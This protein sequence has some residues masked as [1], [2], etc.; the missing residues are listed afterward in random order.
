MNKSRK[1][2]RKSLKKRRIKGSGN[3]GSRSRIEPEVARAQDVAYF[4]VKWTEGF[5]YG[6]IYQD[7]HPN[8]NYLTINLGRD[9]DWIA[10]Q[11]GSRE[12]DDVVA[13]PTTNML[14]LIN[15]EITTFEMMI[16]RAVIDRI[17]LQQRGRSAEELELKRERYKYL[18]IKDFATG[19]LNAEVETRGPISPSLQVARRVN[20]VLPEERF[21]QEQATEIKQAFPEIE[22]SLYDPN[23]W[24]GVRRKS[25]KKK[26]K[27]ARKSIKG[28]K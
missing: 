19:L 20:S 7:Y 1:T 27:R 13:V 6:R 3:C 16:S 24:G 21:P 2:K 28:R 10:Y 4:T 18:A 8:D 15:N 17:R 12:F 14:R 5:T 11:E 23:L 26:R 25:V 22:D 9:T